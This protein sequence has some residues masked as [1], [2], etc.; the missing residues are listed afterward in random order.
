LSDK[1]NRLDAG[2]VFRRPETRDGKD[3]YEIA[4]A[5]ETLD[6]NSAYHY[7]LLCRYFADTSMIAEKQ[8]LVIGFCTAFTPPEAPDTI[9]VWQVAVDHQE[10]GQGIGVRILIEIINNLRSLKIKYLDATITSSNIASIKLFTSAAQQLNAPF[11][12][13]KDFFTAADFGENVHEPEKL[14]HI[15]PIPYS[16]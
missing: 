15:G 3:I 12:F 1:N 14:F 8:G 6:L 7:L 9:F 13:E 16:S 5:S 11:T 2:I 10:R 4:R